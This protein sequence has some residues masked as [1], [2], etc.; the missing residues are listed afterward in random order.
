M[1]ARAPAARQ[2]N[3]RMHRGVRGRPQEDELRHSQAKQVAH[4]C[5][6]VR[7]APGQADI[8]Q[9][10]DLSQTTQHRRRQVERE[11]PVPVGKSRESGMRLEG[12]VQRSVMRQH[13]LCRIQSQHACVEARGGIGRDF[14]GAHARESCIAKLALRTQPHGPT[15]PVR[16]ASSR[17]LR[18]RFSVEGCVV[19]RL[20]NDRPCSGLTMN[21]CA[22]AG[23]CSAGAFSIRR[24]LDS[25]FCSAE[26]SQSGCPE[27]SAPSDPP[28]TRASARWRTGRAWPRAARE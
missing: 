15:D 18:M 12:G 11:S 24:A 16:I 17:S 4:R 25:S 10:I 9:R 8:D 21:R 1:A 6:P 13:R 28:R 23:F 27:I 19:N 20:S 26:A 14:R 22:V 5:Q 7:Q 2:V 3:G